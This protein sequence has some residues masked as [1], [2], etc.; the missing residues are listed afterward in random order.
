MS[1]I[2]CEI[3]LLFTVVFL[4]IWVTSH[5]GLQLLQSAGNWN[6]GRESWSPHRRLTV[7]IQSA[8]VGSPDS[9]CNLCPGL[10]FWLQ[11]SIYSRLTVWQ[12]TSHP[13]PPQTAVRKLPVRIS[14]LFMLSL[15]SHLWLLEKSRG[16][17]NE[18]ITPFSSHSSEWITSSNSQIHYW[19]LPQ[20]LILEQSFQLRARLQHQGIN[21]LFISHLQENVRN[22]W[23]GSRICG[24]L[25]PL[26]WGGS[27][28]KYL[29]SRQTVPVFVRAD[30]SPYQAGFIS[31]RSSRFKLFWLCVMF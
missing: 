15:K 3:F 17:T 28:M 27:Q 30:L 5:R 23:P 12:H 8:A 14:L 9:Q 7:L 31:E 19:F 22:L 6:K 11:H 16:L 26:L 4:S 24:S 1:G 13:N 20:S 2:K 18:T 29:Q 21:R 25:Q 10:M